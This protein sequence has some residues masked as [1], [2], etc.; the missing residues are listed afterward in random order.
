MEYLPNVNNNVMVEG[1]N[2]YILKV[3]SRDRNILN[4]P[5]PF[6]FKIRFNRIDEKYTTYYEKGYF[7]SGN[8][9]INNEDLPT[10]NW[11]E[12]SGY[13]SKTFVVN[14][15]AIIE[16]QIEKIQDINVT[17][18]VVPRF[19][20]DEKVGLEIPCLEAMSCPTKSDTIF[21][22][23]I[24]NTEVKY[25]YDNIS[26][27]GSY[28]NMVEINDVYSNK[29][30]L[31]KESDMSD[32]PI[33]IMKNYYLFNH[34]HTDIIELNSKF[35]KI[36]DIS[37]GTIQL[38]GASGTTVI[39][40]LKSKIRLPKYHLDTIWYQEKDSSISQI[41]N[42]VTF[43]TSSIVFDQSGES[44]ITIEFAKD[45]VLEVVGQTAYTG[46]LTA[47]QTIAFTGGAGCDTATNNVTI[48]ST[49]G[50]SSG[51]VDIGTDGTDANS[52]TVDA[53]VLGSGYKV[54]DT[55]TI[56]KA[57]ITNATSDI[58]FTLTSSHITD[59]DPFRKNSHYFKI[60]SVNYDITLRSEAISYSAEFDS[61]TNIITLKN[62][63]ASQMTY[64]DEIKSNVNTISI[65]G[66][67][68]GTNDTAS[69]SLIEIYKYQSNSYK[70]RTLGISTTQTT[71]A[72][73][74]F[75]MN[76]CKTFPL[77]NLTESEYNE[78]KTF[79]SDSDAAD[80]QNKVTIN[81]SWIYNSSP[82][83]LWK[84]EWKSLQINHLKAGIKDLLNEKLFYLSLDPITPSR[85]LITNNKLNNVIGVFYP[86]TQSKDY[87]FLTGQ[88][89][90]KFTKRNLQNLK[91][92]KFKLY[93]TN[94][95][96]VGE[97]LK[98]YSLDYLEL[99]SKQTNITF[100]IEQID[101]QML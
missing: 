33:N 101:H 76:I 95:K 57:S 24:D 17:E 83:T 11:D 29:F 92:L 66:T 34:Y 22:R 78:M 27:T 65:S 70:I 56:P 81:G 9:W 73:I 86:S 30:Y 69:L 62:L 88:N 7:G 80:I 42:E 32:I 18:I 23:G 26:E 71:P 48:T 43:N 55:I 53:S 64:L 93:Y 79:L 12:T 14:N 91:D 61:T 51:R 52:V 49:S 75:T 84:K 96:Q 16:D 82:T 41:P 68:G 20:P 77:V 60:S 10:S 31:L 63:T 46:P 38:R 13:Y 21:L 100:Q 35:Y 94:G 44:L 4:E 67:T 28:Y 5:N 58:V 90:Q 99:D 89:R 36:I 39:D 6:D 45:T 72:N 19:I 8:K 59:T 2:N 47:S 97:T 54:G 1:T 50:G 40:F 98:N 25:I 3:N 85:N 15:G 87:I 37:N 74:R